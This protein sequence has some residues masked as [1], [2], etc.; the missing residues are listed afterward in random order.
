[1]V[2]STVSSDFSE[3]PQACRLLTVMGSGLILRILIRNFPCAW[4]AHFIQ[5]LIYNHGNRMLQSDDKKATL[6]D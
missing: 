4:M 5:R 2:P 3:F 6:R 1:M